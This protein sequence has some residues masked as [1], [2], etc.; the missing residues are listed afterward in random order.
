MFQWTTVNPAPLEVVAD[1]LEYDLYDVPSLQIT[2]SVLLSWPENTQEEQIVVSADSLASNAVWKPW[3]QP[4]FKQHQRLHLTVPLSPNAP[5]Q[6]FKLVPGTQFF[7]DFSPPKAPFTARECWN[8]CFCGNYSERFECIN[9]NGSYSITDRGASTD[10]KVLVLPPGP[11]II[12]GDFSASVDLLDWPASSA[13]IF[14]GIVARACCD[15]ANFPSGTQGLIGG[16]YINDTGN[17][18][19]GRLAVEGQAAGPYFSLVR[20]EDYCLQFS[21]VGSE[22]RVALL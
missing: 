1:N 9:T 21:A 22:L 13:P 10:A 18:G 19:K 2:N 15:A 20:S 12:V 5:E 6:Y 3:P 14:V 4:L 17:I 16:L 11:G 8:P 7:D